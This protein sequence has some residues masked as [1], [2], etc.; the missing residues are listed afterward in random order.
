MSVYSCNYFHTVFYN[1]FTKNKPYQ[2]YGIK[3]V[4]LSVKKGDLYYL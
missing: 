1:Y 3:N 4:N 2:Y